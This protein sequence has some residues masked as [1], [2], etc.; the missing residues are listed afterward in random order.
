M[1][2]LQ[3][4]V[5]LKKMSQNK[6]F[7][8][9][10][11]H[12]YL[13]LLIGVISAIYVFPLIFVQVPRGHDI[14]FHLNRIDGLAQELKMGNLP[15]RLYTT[16]LN[17]YGYAAP[18]FY[19]DL[20]LYFP[21]ALVVAGVE[22]VTAYKILVMVSALLTGL[23][24]Y[25]SANII[26]KD[27]RAAWFAAMLY[28]LSTY[29]A[30]DMF[31][32]H[33]MGEVLSFIF[34]P[35]AIAGLHVIINEPLKLM[36]RWVLLPLGMYG[37][38]QS[39]TML[40]TASTFFLFLYA[41]LSVKKIIRQPKRLLYIFMSV[42]LFALFSASFIF[43]MIEQMRSGTFRATDGTSAGYLGTLAQR[44]LPGVYRLF[45]NLISDIIIEEEV[46]FL[47]AGL[48]WAFPLIM[49][50]HLIYRKHFTSKLWL[51]Y[52]ALGGISLFMVSSYFPW[53]PFQDALGVLQFS[54][55]LLL[56]V[57]V[58]FS[59]YG[60]F[61]IKHT[62]K[63]K[64][65][66]LF[67]AV[68][69]V[70]SLGIAAGNVSDRYSYSYYKAGRQ[71]KIDYPYE[72]SIGLGE[73][74]PT[75]TNKSSL[76]KRGERVN[77]KNPVARY[78]LYRDKGVL[79]LVF[80]G[81]D[82]PDNHFDLPL[83]MYKGYKATLTSGDEVTDIPLTYGDN[84]IVRA[85]IGPAQTGTLKVWYGGTLTQHLTFAITS[86]SFVALG[87]LTALTAYKKRRDKSSQP[88]NKLEPKVASE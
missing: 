27:K 36:G 25:Y 35:L 40:A 21:A 81:N 88:Q 47:P 34:L 55:R 20:L 14:Y 57:T 62:A 42:G 82:S 86:V 53:E 38:L 31:T 7:C 48:G 17:N 60:G 10:V 22:V 77:A 71:E 54:W 69:T 11:K 68:I 32:R 76:L 15:V 73:Y 9:F 5:F 74:L 67:M 83:L 1:P 85:T 65:L 84:N 59:F 37:F 41:L 28:S 66:I 61:V 4:K 72:N 63:A 30:A 58:F 2:L 33:A 56:F 19:G 51:L 46:C 70:L 16:A 87:V 6:I 3:R 79:T 13:Y 18:L 75:G 24:M 29:L 8:H 64:Y 52:F 39:H 12:K 23:S 80:E 43:P 44:T 49:I 26:L 45:A 78:D 50:W